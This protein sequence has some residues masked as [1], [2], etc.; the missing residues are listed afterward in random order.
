MTEQEVKE[1]ASG[2]T[3]IRRA[4]RVVAWDD[5]ERAH[6]YLTDADVAFADG[7][8]SFVGRGYEGPRRR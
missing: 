7:K 4:D 1:G 3:L 8:L 5:A 6:V 2:T